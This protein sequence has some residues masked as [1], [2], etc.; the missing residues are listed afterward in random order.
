M[1]VGGTGH[2]WVGHA[3]R[4]DPGRRPDRHG[5][6]RLRAVAGS[7]CQT[8]ASTSAGH[9]AGARVTSRKR[10]LRSAETPHSRPLGTTNAPFLASWPKSQ[11]A[12]RLLELCDRR[13]WVLP[14]PLAVP[15]AE[16]AVP[17]GAARRRVASC[18]ESAR[19]NP[20]RESQSETARNVPIK[21]LRAIATLV[22]SRAARRPGGNSATDLGRALRGARPHRNGMTRGDGACRG[23]FKHARQRG[24]SSAPIFVVTS[25]AL[26]LQRDVMNT[27][28]CSSFS[29]SV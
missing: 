5:Q 17:E 16:R 4:V 12:R 25:G 23:H 10:L 22:T 20:R 24:H 9:A 6:W 15:S 26:H 2:G 19:P 21:L 27:K 28:S 29:A 7:E 14:C 3:D 18:N 8:L 1:S 11:S 13:S